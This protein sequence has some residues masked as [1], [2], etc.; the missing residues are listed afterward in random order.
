MAPTIGGG[1]IGALDLLI[2]A[3][4]IVSAALLFAFLRFTK[5][6]FAVRATAQDREA[7]QQMGVNVNAVNS[8][9]FAI[10]SALGGLSG[11]LV[12]MYYN[13]IDPAMSFQ[14][15]LKGVVAQV[16]GGVGNVPGA[17]VGSRILGLDR[18]L[19]HR[20]F[21][22]DLSQS[23]CLRPADRLPAVVSKRAVR[24]PAR[25]AI[26]SRSPEPSLRRAD[27]SAVPRWLVSALPS[28]LLRCRFV[29]SAPYLL[30]TLTNAWLAAMLALSLTFVAGTADRSRSVRPRFWRLAAMRRRCWSSISARRDRLR[31]RPPG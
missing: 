2:A 26:P 4:G 15:T 18:K 30:Q 1:S 28:Q 20:R 29:T 23:L 12:G 19:W 9:V 16:I 5:L 17:I 8:A 13:H 22:H 3:V 10:A 31:C 21:R 14:A 11:L 27:R 24:R 7:A 6:G 25:R